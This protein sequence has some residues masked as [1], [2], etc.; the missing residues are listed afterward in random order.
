MTDFETI[1]EN[2]SN[3]DSIR[4]IVLSGSSTNDSA[5]ECSDLDVYIYTDKEVDLDIRKQIAEKYAINPSLNNT[6]WETGDEMLIK[7]SG[8]GLDIMYRDPSWIESMIENVWVKHY[9]S[10]GYT[11]CFLHNIK[12]SKILYD[13][14]GWFKNLQDKIS[15][16]YPE[17]LSKNIIKKNLPVLKEK[18]YASYYG[19]IK[20]AIERKDYV[21]VN[22]R[23]T[24]F[25]ASYFDIIFALNKVFHPGEK[26][27][28]HYV[29]TKCAK[30]PQNFEEDVN[31]LLTAPYDKK[32]EKL[33]SL[34]EKLTT[35][36]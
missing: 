24:V 32:L 18:K 28:I 31:A 10:L 2:F 8:K 29:K 7:D 12:T 17:E 16:E 13:K 15:G 11:T 5:D 20:C 23:T 14:T 9:A 19:Q 34:V 25:L 4:A 1:I 36:L 27:L 26:R 21:A 3:V 22:H 33:D 6:Y 30:I 35:I